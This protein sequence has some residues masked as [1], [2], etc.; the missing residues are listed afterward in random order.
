MWVKS[1]QDIAKR[2][3][4]ASKFDSVYYLQLNSEGNKLTKLK[5]CATC[6]IFRPPRA[7]HCATCENCIT[8][9]DH[10]CV[11]LGTCIGKRNYGYFLGFIFS[12]LILILLSLYLGFASILL[13]RNEL[14][15]G[16]IIEQS[17]SKF[18]F[19]VVVILMSL[20]FG[21]F[22]LLLSIFHCRLVKN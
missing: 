9:F 2:Y 8:E 1:N 17:L 13:Y 12:L 3:I 15:D 7:S 4:K 20:V 14:I 11:W 21:L 10:H 19:S 18:P 6:W 22:V 16:N 5:Y